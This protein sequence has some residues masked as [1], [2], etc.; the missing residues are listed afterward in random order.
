MGGEIHPLCGDAY[1]L[2]GLWSLGWYKGALREAIKA[3]KYRRV[4]DIA[5][6]LGD[7]II[8]YWQKFEPIIFDEIKRNKKEWVITSVPLHWW[9][10][11]QRGFNQSLLIG[12]ILSKKLGLEY[13]DALKRI[14]YTKPQV[15]LKGSARRQNIKDAFVLNSKFEFRSAEGSSKNNSNFLLVDDVWTT[16]STLKECCY[17]LKKNGAQKIWAITLAR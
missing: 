7:L 14:R 9:R 13:C 15:K 16:G 8:D 4:H 3:F 10:S 17:V 1:S 5:E 11:N 6:A 12:Q 2:D